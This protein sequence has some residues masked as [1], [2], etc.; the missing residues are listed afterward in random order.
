MSD[1][2]RGIPEIV[3]VCH[4]GMGGGKI[5][6]TMQIKRNCAMQ[7]LHKCNHSDYFSRQVVKVFV[8]ILLKN[9]LQRIDLL[10]VQGFFVGFIM[11]H[12]FKQINCT[13]CANSG[14][15]EIFD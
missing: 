2:E 15:I 10:L 7:S 4:N 3:T 5:I 1:E 13:L 11:F 9:I 12:C 14:H 6:N 8:E